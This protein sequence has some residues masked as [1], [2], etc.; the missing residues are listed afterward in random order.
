MWRLQRRVSVAGEVSPSHRGCFCLCQIAPTLRHA[1]AEFI[2]R[3]KISDGLLVRARV[4][5]RVEQVKDVLNELLGGD[6]LRCDE[7]FGAWKF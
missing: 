1:L 6:F 4:P 5:R 2:V 7:V 3:A